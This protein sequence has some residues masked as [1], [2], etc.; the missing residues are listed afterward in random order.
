[1]PQPQLA[2]LL[3]QQAAIMLEVDP[4]WSNEGDK[5]AQ[6]VMLLTLGAD[7]AAIF[8]AIVMI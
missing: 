1:M 8:L 4:T 6:S 2:F 3:S 7:L 5:I